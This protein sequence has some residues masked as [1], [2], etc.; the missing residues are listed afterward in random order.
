MY[1]KKILYFTDQTQNYRP[2]SNRN[3]QKQSKNVEIMSKTQMSTSEV[4]A[5]KALWKSKHI[6][7]IKLF[8]AFVVMVH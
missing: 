5:G 3:P 1:I 8:I 7:Q 4:R 6:K 2:Y